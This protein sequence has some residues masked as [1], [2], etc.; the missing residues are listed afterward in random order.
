M[1]KLGPVLPFL[2]SA[3][4]LAERRRGYFLRQSFFEEHLL[5]LRFKNLFNFSDHKKL[6]NSVMGLKSIGG[7]VR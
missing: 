7:F 4:S 5:N 6:R 2:F 3:D 1:K